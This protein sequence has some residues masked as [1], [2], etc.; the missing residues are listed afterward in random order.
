M[1]LEQRMRQ[2]ESYIAAVQQVMS[3]Y[4]TSN[5]GCEPMVLLASDDDQAVAAFQDSFGDR[6]LCREAVKRSQGGINERKLPRE[7]HGQEE[8]L[9]LEDAQDCLIDALLLAE[10]DA[11][12]HADSNLTIAVGIMNPHSSAFHV[13]DLVDG[14]EAGVW[15]VP[16][17]SVKVGGLELDMCK[18]GTCRGVVDTGTSHLGIPGPHDKEL[19][20]MLKVDAGDL[21]DCR[22]AQSPKLE[23]E[24]PGKTIELFASS[25]M[26]RLPLREGVS[27][28]SEKGVTL[29]ENDKKKG[30]RKE[31]ARFERPGYVKLEMGA[32][33]EE[34]K[35][36]RPDLA[37]QCPPEAANRRDDI[38]GD[39]FH[40]HTRGEEICVNRTDLPGGWGMNLAFYCPEPYV[41]EKEG[42]AEAGVES[43]FLGDLD[44][45][46][47]RC[48]NTF[49]ELDCQSTD[50]FAVRKEDRLK[51]CVTRKHTNLVKESDV[52]RCKLLV[53][54]ALAGLQ[55]VVIGSQ[56]A[57]E[58]QKCVMP[59]VPVTCEPES[60]N[61]RKDNF[62]D[63][64]E[65]FEENNQICARRTDGGEANWA[66]NLIIHCK[67]KLEAHQLPQN[68]DREEVHLQ[69]G[70]NPA[71]EENNQEQKEE[72]PEEPQQVTRHCSPRLMA[73]NLPAPL[74]PK[75]FILGEPVLHRYY[76]VYDWEEKRVGF[77]LANTQRNTMDL[78]Q[79]GR[80]TLPKEDTEHG[81]PWCTEHA[82]TRCS[83]GWARWGTRAREKHRRRF[84]I[85]SSSLGAKKETPPA[86]FTGVVRWD[87]ERHGLPDRPGKTGERPTGTGELPGVQLGQLG[88]LES[89]CTHLGL[90]D[91]H[92]WLKVL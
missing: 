2:T 31:E 48:Y 10:C 92:D 54:S 60:G 79:L 29:D 49:A 34:M 24:L 9:S 87:W 32:S 58:M 80:G 81:P 78:S 21:L 88:R 22:L 62:P 44:T 28:S 13:R 67:P 65:I 1:Q 90:P 37:V 68:V 36:M 64:F 72:V 55:E 53:D 4:A 70:E 7:V 30:K 39:Q 61:R 8:R 66:L 63:T 71:K 77:S 11:F 19:G 56:T 35:C 23:I 38:Y 15:V 84:K 6:L 42:T 83:E 14:S 5:G 75:L 47:E 33:R 17:L 89:K 41:A 27:V 57:G 50:E 16:I 25:Y 3:Q 46:T 52:M 82:A 91:L 85:S 20:K 74:G 12:V 76:T 59:E 51:V 43:I 69:Q 73:V 26:R 18:D 86:A 45:D 40:V